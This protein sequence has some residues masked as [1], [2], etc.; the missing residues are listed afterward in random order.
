MAQPLSNKNNK[1]NGSSSIPVDVCDRDSGTEVPHSPGAGGNTQTPAKSQ[2]STRILHFFTY[3][4][5]ENEDWNVIVPIVLRFQQCGVIKG[6]IQSETCPST[7]KLH[8]HGFLKCKKRMRDTEFNVSKRFN[9]RKVMNEAA[10]MDYCR[11][12]REQWPSK[13]KSPTNK[14]GDYNGDYC[15]E[16]GFPVID[17]ITPDRP[18]QKQILDIV[19]GPIDNRAVYWFYEGTGGVG[20]SS[21]CKYLCVVK[22]ALFISEGKK[23]DLINI[24]Y[25]ADMERTRLVVIDVPR[26]NGNNVSYKAIEEIKNGLICNTKYETG[27]KAFNPPH[28][29]VFSNFLPNVKELSKDRWHIYHINEDFTTYQIDVEPDEEML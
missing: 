26:N 16:W 4:P 12:G 9:W 19:N 17:L 25:N 18:Y 2:V 11:K 13:D 22:K 23:S 27:M 15:I 6:I 20:K 7:G 14:L 21:L 24:I 28:L 29:I 10:A 1:H 5:E 3:F 8:F